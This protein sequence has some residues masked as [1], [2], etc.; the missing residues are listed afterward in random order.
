MVKGENIVTEA[1]AM[2]LLLIALCITVIGGGLAL[3]KLI[4]RIR[5]RLVHQYERFIIFRHKRFHRL[6]GPG[7][8]LYCAWI[9]G[10]EDTINV[11]EQSQRFNITT[12]VSDM[13]VTYVLE[14]R[15]RVD[16]VGAIGRD[17]RKLE[18]AL[19]FDQE[20]R[21][22]QIDKRLKDL[23]PKLLMKYQL[24]QTSAPGSRILHR[25]LPYVPG[26]PNLLKLLQE[27]KAEATPIL[28]R[29][30]VILNPD[31]PILVDS[32]RLEPDV[33]STLNRGREWAE[34]QHQL[35]TNLSVNEWGTVVAMLQNAFDVSQQHYQINTPSNTILS[36]SI[37]EAGVL[38]RQLEKP[39]TVRA[40]E[41]VQHRNAVRDGTPVDVA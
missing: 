20:E 31:E 30:G 6:A 9:D 10:V 36:Q 37:V 25:L 29:Y 14:M 22:I 28:R 13:M 1:F 18:Y 17:R 27:M 16:P 7:W 23:L 21:Q 15:Y 35:P 34:L 3:F 12:Y 4:A 8:I 32:I 24:N 41:T 19:E 5:F 26:H 39:R 38:A 11:K 33:A 40:N 2:M